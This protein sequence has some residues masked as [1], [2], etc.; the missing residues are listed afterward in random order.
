MSA[1]SIQVPF[2]V[3]QDRDGQP[4]SNG[5][6]WI[7]QANLNPQTNPVIAYFDAA[8]TIPAQQ[9]LRTINGYVSNAG[10]PAQIYVDGVNFSILVQD[11]K[12]SMV[13]NFP[14][15]TGI[16]PNASGVAFT[17][18]KGQVGFV[19]DIADDDGSDWIG[20]EPAGTG[21]VA[22]SAQDKMRETVSVKDFGA[23]GDGVTD[24]A[25]AV[26]N[27]LQYLVAN[28]VA[29]FVPQGTYLLGSK[30]TITNV[31]KIAIYGD[32][33]L[34]SIFKRADNVV[35][36]SFNEMFS[37]T[38]QSGGLSELIV[39]GIGFDGNARGNQIPVDITGVSGT[40]QVGEQLVGKDNTIGTVSAGQLKFTRYLNGLA[41]GE[42]ITGATSGATAT[43]VTA[44]SSFIWQQSHC[45]RTNTSGSLAWNLVVFDDIYATDPTADVLGMGGSNI[46]TYGHISVT[47]LFVQERNRVRSDI[48]VTGAYNS[49]RIANCKTFSTEVEL[50]V[51][52][53]NQS[54][55]T[56]IT[57]LITDTLDLDT[58]AGSVNVYPPMTVT[59]VIVNNF[60]FF[61]GYTGYFSNC[62]FLVSSP[63]RLVQG[64]WQFSGCKFFA[65]SDLS[66]S[67]EGLLFQEGNGTNARSLRVNDCVFD[68]DPSAVL[69]YYY[70]DP[71]SWGSGS[72]EADC[73]PFVFSNCKFTGDTIRTAFL[74]G[75]KFEFSRCTHEYAGSAILY[76][77]PGPVPESEIKLFDNV[78]TD[79]AGYLITPP[80]TF[81]AP[82]T[83]LNLW[84]RDNVSET[85]GQ[86]IDFTRYDKIAPPHGAATGANAVLYFKQVDKQYES[87]VTP[88]TGKWLK[89]SVVWNS[90]PAPSGKVGW[91]VTTS[92]TAGSGAVFKP[93]GVIDA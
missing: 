75:G 44:V 72:T 71:N 61:D 31:N 36:S 5:Y 25:T 67:G 50:N 92:G 33:S 42:V 53:V 22:R 39:K 37:L 17:G 41:T 2:P 85:L 46:N 80:I 28:N 56:V 68:A 43:V 1:L 23:V 35:T 59:N 32:G 76:G 51:F 24:D 26:R 60:A 63:I 86:I 89:G 30:I 74:R 90:A 70:Y 54:Y 21:A 27:W 3:F 6:V 57:N 11:S 91:S 4:L 62:Q 82:S 48:T 49:L 73:V 7:G 20:F 34:A 9:P 14:N 83:G 81:T 84:M 40:F 77:T 64:K 69:T 16:S 65:N 87:D 78:V 88:T 13:Y 38:N 52:T 12:G 47:N 18:F 10:T 79:A 93:F 66:A 8:L 19:S 29:G 45:I 58:S 15:G 55:N